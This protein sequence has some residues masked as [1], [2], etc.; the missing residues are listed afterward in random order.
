MLLIWVALGSASLL[1]I[2]VIGLLISRGIDDWRSLRLW[3]RRRI[4]ESGR[5]FQV[6]SRRVLPHEDDG[7]GTYEI[8]GVLERSGAATRF[9]VEAT[10]VPDA[11]R[12]A[13]QRGVVPAGVAK[14]P[15]N[16]VAEA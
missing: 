8:S 11:V 16:T 1:A 2:C 3:Y 14:R 15:L 10:G 12:Q 7:P 6:M 4:G 5:A 13:I 9:Q